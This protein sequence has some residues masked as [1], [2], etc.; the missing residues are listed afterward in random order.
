MLAARRALGRDPI[1]KRQVA[2]SAQ[3]FAI[4]NR[5]LYTSFQVHTISPVPPS[6]EAAAS[7]DL[8]YG[9]TT[10]LTSYVV[11]DN[12]RG[13]VS[14]AIWALTNTSSLNTARAKVKLHLT[15]ITSP[16]NNPFSY[17]SSL[18]TVIE[19]CA[20]PTPY[21]TRRYNISKPFALKWGN[22][23]TFLFA[24]TA[25]Q[26]GDGTLWIGFS[27]SIRDGFTRRFGAAVA[28]VQPTISAAPGSGLP[29]LAATLKSYTL[30]YSQDHSLIYP[31]LAVNS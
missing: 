27:A 9:G 1:L 16:D 21:G 17:P 12:D 19:Q 8:R 23:G 15:L 26:S 31:A 18:N 10:L 20:G 6:A 28:L 24:T 25:S 7:F 4:P 14:L 22:D 11:D 2:F 13:N 30:F 3:R 5:R 29:V